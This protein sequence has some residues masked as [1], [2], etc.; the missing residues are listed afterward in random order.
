MKKLITILGPTA[1]GKSDLAVVLARK[2]NG[3]V[4]SADSRQVYRGMDLGSGKI[5]KKEMMGIPH[6]LLDIV[7]PKKRFDVARY[8]RLADQCIAKIIQKGKL[9]ILCGG[10]AFYIQAVVDGLVIPAVKPDWRLRTRLERFKTEKLFEKLRNLDPERARN[11]DRY[12]RRRLVRSLEI[13]LKTKKPVPSLRKKPLPYPVL[14][15]GIKKTPEELKK[16]IAIRLQKRLKAGM[17]AEIKTLHQ[18]GVSWK[19][20]E[21]F[22]LEY[23]FIARYLQKKISCETMLRL[24]RK[25][26]EHFAK[27]QMT[28]FKR[29]K[30][31]HWIKTQ[32][33]AETLTEQY[34]RE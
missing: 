15:I 18:K 14:I 13:V 8:R 11:I 2:F 7:S 25:E 28:W 12:N 34:L 30:R 16:L 26:C 1:A 27:R 32:K 17:V 24:I 29:D 33:Q 22:G 31:I 5:T 4:I 23:R 3:E 10:T 6:H 21:E 9:P 19:R 20:L